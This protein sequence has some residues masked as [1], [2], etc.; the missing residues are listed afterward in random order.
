[1]LDDGSEDNSHGIRDSYSYL[2]DVERRALERVI[3]TVGDEAVLLL[4]SSNDRD[5]Q[6]YIIAKFIQRELGAA[7]AE[8]NQIHQQGP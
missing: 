5:K 6:H 3:S 2:S 8:V 1:M 4:L 7:Q